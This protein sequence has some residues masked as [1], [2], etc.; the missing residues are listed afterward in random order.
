M[1]I[2]V[3]LGDVHAQG[4]AAGD[5]Q[6]QREQQAWR[7][8]LWHRLLGL[9]TSKGVEVRAFLNDPSSCL[10]VRIPRC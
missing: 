1:D 6:L 9:H 8:R 5:Q 4:A 7:G 2:G 10:V 3:S